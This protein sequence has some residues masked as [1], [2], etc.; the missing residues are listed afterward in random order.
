[1]TWAP[2]WMMVVVVLGLSLQ[3][4]TYLLAF[5]KCGVGNQLTSWWGLLAV[6]PAGMFLNAGTLQCCSLGTLSVCIRS[7]FFPLSL[8]ESQ[9]RFFA[10]CK[11][12]IKRCGSGKVAITHL[13]HLLCARKKCFFF[14]LDMHSIISRFNQET[15][16][17]KITRSKPR[18]FYFIRVYIN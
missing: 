12:M 16:Q 17:K 6:S 8:S 18:I 15:W 2:M 13:L 4:L 5:E 11:E 14:S 1:M 9:W 10:A 7:S 3:C